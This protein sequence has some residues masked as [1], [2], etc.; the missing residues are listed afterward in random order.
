MRIMY[1]WDDVKVNKPFGDR[2]LKTTQDIIYEY[3]VAIKTR[4][5]VDFLMPSWEKD[6]G[7]ANKY[8]TDTIN[9][10]I[11]KGKLDLEELANDPDFIEFMH[12]RYEDDAYNDFKESN[13]AY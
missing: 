5:V 9:Y 2:T 8:M 3:S 1:C 10:L 4:D 12:D 6:K 13:D 7:T 11:D